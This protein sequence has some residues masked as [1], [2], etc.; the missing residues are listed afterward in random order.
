[1]LIDEGVN[2]PQWLD[3]DVSYYEY[4][5]EIMYESLETLLWYNGSSSTQIVPWLS[6]SWT[7]SYNVVS[8]TY[9][10]T[11]RPGIKFQDGY[12]LNS[13]AVW[14][15]LTRLLILD[16]TAGDNSVHGSQA[17]WIIQQ[18]LNTSLSSGLDGPQ[19][20]SPTW[21][22]EVLDE[23][24][25]QIMNAST[26]KI[27]I[28][29]PT[30]QFPYLLSNAWASI[31]S[32]WSV[33]PQEYAFNKWGTWD[34]NY[35][36][37]FVKAAGDG[38]TYYDVPTNGWKIG[39]GPYYLASYDPTT[40]KVVLKVNP[41]YWGGPPN[42]QYP[43]GTPTIKEIDFDYVADFSTRLLD[44]KGEQAT[45]IGVSSADI[46][47]VINQTTWLNSGVFASLIPGVTVQ[48]P[49][50]RFVTD[51]FNFVT[52]TTSSTGSLLK[53]QPMA[54]ERIR[55]AICDAVNLTEINIDVNNRL[56]SVPN[57]LIPPGT[58]PAG[59]YNASIKLP[60]SY[61]LT[62]AAIL[63]VDAM[64]HPLTSFTYENGT[65][66]PPGIVN[67]TF[68]PNNPQTIPIYYIAGDTLDEKLLTG[69]A[70]NLNTIATTN[71]TGLT[72]TLVPVPGGEQYTLESEH[73]IYMNWGG[74]VADYNNVLDWL[75]AMY[76]STGTYPLWNNMNYTTLDMYVKNA[77]A[78]DATGNL[79]G[80]LYWNCLANEFANKEVMYFY[81]FYPEAYFVRSSFLQDFYY[82]PA[83]DV[84]YFAAMHYSTTA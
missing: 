4:D 50:S 18:L 20:Y 35:T 6:E 22:K 60:Y 32:P 30:A 26:F 28:M 70:T 15:S 1:V 3:P 36:E 45:L 24:F 81:N 71:N 44:L 69:L 82:N 65:R 23:N 39:T 64:N 43:V 80:E 38:V 52:N 37:Y 16:G 59:V 2:K 77:K 63:I 5:F 78:A 73:Q 27:N 61:N 51:W 10:V 21:V 55:L 42:L 74:W 7:P 58:A 40:Y 41:T 75:D 46:Y 56:G 57:Q 17:A 49:Y 19:S 47:S 79:T 72:F 13:T 83:L 8:S 34:G 62:E 67:N 66:I 25:I 29:H 9:T 76:L 84:P 12:P 11:L 33:I 14:F 53:F 48:G 54:D 31:I 68:G